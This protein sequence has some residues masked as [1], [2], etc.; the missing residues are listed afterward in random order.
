[1]SIVDLFNSNLNDTKPLA[2]KT[3]NVSAPVPMHQLFSKNHNEPVAV[4]EPSNPSSLLFK[5]SNVPSNNNKLVE[6]EDD[7]QVTSNVE[8]V[9]SLNAKYIQVINQINEELMKLKSDATKINAENAS[10]KKENND[11]SK[12]VSELSNAVLNVVQQN[13][14]LS[15]ALGLRS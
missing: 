2:K 15:R 14:T 1:M 12:K 13:K 8:H 3:S 4:A 11:L 6:T 7:S 9:R 5:L 10:L